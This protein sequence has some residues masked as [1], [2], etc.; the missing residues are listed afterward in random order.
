[1]TQ[2]NDLPVI[3][4]DSLPSSQQQLV[5]PVTRSSNSEAND[6]QEL[7]TA[8]K[9]TSKDEGE[10]KTLD[11]ILRLAGLANAESLVPTSDPKSF[12]IKTRFKSTEA[13]AKEK[14]KDDDEEEEEEEDEEEDEDDDDDD[15]EEKEK[16]IYII[17][18][19]N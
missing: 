6:Q 13:S 9:S 17:H 19:R 15:D 16:V 1:M 7:T 14:E 3:E 4:M 8:I 12:M 10:F 11:E 18:K 5:N 2:V